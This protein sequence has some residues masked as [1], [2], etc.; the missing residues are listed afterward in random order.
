MNEPNKQKDNKLNDKK[1]NLPSLEKTLQ[2]KLKD[3]KK[4]LGQDIS[5]EE[6]DIID[7]FEKPRMILQRIFITYNQ[8]RKAMG[9]PLLKESE[10]R[11][12]LSNL[13]KNGYLVIEKFK[14]DGKDQEAFIL[15]EKGKQMLE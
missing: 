12:R 9:T 8:T 6:H 11:E 1:G 2:T 14:Y 7:C 5:P 3:E 4:L 15:T 10:I 13:E